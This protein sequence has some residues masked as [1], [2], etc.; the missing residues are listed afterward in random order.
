MVCAIHVFHN[1]WEL[2]TPFDTWGHPSYYLVTER[3]PLWLMMM[4]WLYI[5]YLCFWARGRLLFTFTIYI[6][7]LW[8][9]LYLALFPFTF[10][11]LLFPILYPYSFIYPLILI[12]SAWHIFLT[13]CTILYYCFVTVISIHWAL[14]AQPHFFSCG[15]FLVGS[16]VWVESTIGLRRL[17]CDRYFVIEMTKRIYIS[18]LVFIPL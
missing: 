4:A 6:T 13:L 3:T 14:V 12:I 9:L 8:P 11:Y 10:T 2:A 5:L 7:Y 17:H 16:W 15:R 18:D 1:L